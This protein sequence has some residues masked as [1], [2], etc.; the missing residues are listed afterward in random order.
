MAAQLKL[1]NFSPVLGPRVAHAF[2]DFHE[3]NG[4]S[5]AMEDPSAS[6]LPVNGDISDRIVLD[7]EKGVLLYRATLNDILTFS[8]ITGD[9]NSVH[10]EGNPF[11]GEALVQGNL[12]ASL[13]ESL[14]AAYFD[15]NHF[16]HVDRYFNENHSWI[17]N[18][19]R[20][21]FSHF[22]VRNKYIGKLSYTFRD[23]FYPGDELELRVDRFEFRKKADR[24]CKFSVTC[25]L[26]HPRKRESALAKRERYKPGIIKIEYD[27]VLQP[28]QKLADTVKG[29]PLCTDQIELGSDEFESYI[30][31]LRCRQK[32]PVMFPVV[33]TNSRILL[34]RLSEMK[35]QGSASFGTGIYQSYK[36]KLFKGARKLKLGDSLRS[37]YFSNELAA[38]ANLQAV[39]LYVTDKDQ[40]ILYQFNAPILLLQEPA[41]PRRSDNG[42]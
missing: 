24:D 36:V 26:S 2:L 18:P 11:F 5:A 22:A 35:E 16:S 38:D 41:Q 12:I 6:S 23:E 1:E 31:M 15:R 13:A 7:P 8:D 3:R 34:K 10:K 25:H 17:P 30:N 28:G 33:Y 39:T 19:F 29:E 9:H 27:L 40:N 42:L 4:S 32:L 37:F 21:L 20:K 14:V